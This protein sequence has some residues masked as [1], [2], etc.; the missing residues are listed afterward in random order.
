M[1]PHSVG[2]RV[3]VCVAITVGLD[4]RSRYADE[5]HSISRLFDHL[6]LP[7]HHMHTWKMI[8]GNQPR[9]IRIC[10]QNGMNRNTSGLYAQN[11]RN[12]ENMKRCANAT[13]RG[14]DMCS[15]DAKIAELM[16]YDC[17]GER[18]ETD[19]DCRR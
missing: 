14:E 5:E 17:M 9:E 18:G 19:V 3:L 12:M 6:D 11:T 13:P 1:A 16:R 10:N 2:G 15:I 7:A 8:R 4:A